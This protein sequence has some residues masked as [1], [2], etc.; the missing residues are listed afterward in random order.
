[1]PRDATRLMFELSMR[2]FMKDPDNP[3]LREILDQASEL[4]AGQRKAFLDTACA[5]NAE[6]RAEVEALLASL[7]GANEF[8]GEPTIEPGAVRP[9]TTVDAGPHVRRAEG[10]GGRIDRYKLLQ[11]IGEGGFGSVF[12]AEQQTPVVRKV[13][14][15]VIK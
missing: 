14:L 2:P 7:E 9:E 4:P 15:K 1:M 3:L 11:L 5:A 12:M 10:P 8:L 13:A 6:L